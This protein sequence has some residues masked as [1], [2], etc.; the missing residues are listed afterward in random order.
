MSITVKHRRGTAVEHSS[1][2]GANGEITMDTT[3]LTL[4]VHDGVTVGGHRL[5]KYTEL[6]SIVSGTFSSNIEPSSNNV[7]SVGNTENV[8]SQIYLG[9]S[10][11]SIGETE[12]YASGNTLTLNAA[13]T[14]ITSLILTNVLGTEYG[15]TGLSSFTENGVLFGANTSTLGFVTGT[16]GEI[17]QI[18]TSGVP[19]F[20]DLDG[21]EFS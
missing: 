7:Y 6:G 4:R 16:S 19:T 5:A 9:D 1:F 20:D 3:N 17:L 14:S 11:V 10:G 15:G 8:W 21:G 2:T 12:I 13:T 18:N